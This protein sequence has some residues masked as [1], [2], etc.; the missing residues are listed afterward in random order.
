M[1]AGHLVITPPVL[2]VPHTDWANQLTNAFSPT[3]ILLRLLHTQH[4]FGSLLPPS[5][6]TTFYRRCHFKIHQHQHIKAFIDALCIVYIICIVTFNDTSWQ[7]I[8][9]TKMRIALYMTSFIPY[10]SKPS[11]ILETSWHV[12][13]KHAPYKFT[14]V[15]YSS[16]STGKRWSTLSPHFD[17]S[18]AFV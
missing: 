15:I 9:H 17:S 11:S 2:P 12:I 1:F 5:H 4:T 14:F 6:C 18:M 16:I 13:Q 3:V 7:Q 8:S 10:S